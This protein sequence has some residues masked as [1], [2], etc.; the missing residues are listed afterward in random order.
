MFA[1]FVFSLQL[2]HPPADG[3]QPRV[4]EQQMHRNSNTARSG[5][6]LDDRQ[7]EVCASFFSY[8]FAIF[9][10]ILY[11][12]RHTVNYRLLYIEVYAVTMHFGCLESC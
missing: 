8:D 3:R 2:A 10:T 6:D 9:E 7:Q 4:A 1:F 12:I 5:Q 11:F